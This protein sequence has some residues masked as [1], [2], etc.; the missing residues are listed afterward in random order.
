[1]PSNDPTPENGY[2]DWYVNGDL[3]KLTT[4]YSKIRLMAHAY[5][6]KGTNYYK[7]PELLADIKAA[8]EYGYNNYYGSYIL[9]HGTIANWYEWRIGV[10][11]E[12][13]ATL[14]YI[15]DELTQAEINKY[16][17]PFDMLMPFPVGAASNLLN[18][19]YA[20][21]LAGALEKDYERIATAL[22]FTSDIYKYVTIDDM[23]LGTDGGF[24]ADGSFVQHNVTP[25]HGS[26]GMG[27]IQTIPVV[28]YIVTD[29]AF[30]I[31]DDKL[32]IQAWWIT[33]SFAHIMYGDKLMSTTSGRAVGGTS[34]QGMYNGVLK[35][36]IQMLPYVPDSIA[37]EFKQYVRTQMFIYG[38]SLA[39]SL[40]IVYYDYATTLISVAGILIFTDTSY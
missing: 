3:A 9:E 16:L 13:C 21:I 39:T 37:P 14:A 8:L 18:M 38:S 15:K 23:G 10:P 12:L 32:E 36:M 29:T 33:D 27:L 25:Y 17:A 40:P 31:P 7:N 34:E 19:S 35:A 24:F 30:A 20:C 1:M 28:T 5:T 26:Y 4:L 11:Q 2:D 6:F 22:Y